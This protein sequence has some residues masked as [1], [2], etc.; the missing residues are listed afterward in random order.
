LCCGPAQDAELLPVLADS[1]GQHQDA[2]GQFDDVATLFMSAMEQHYTP[3]QI[4]DMWNWSV[5]TVIRRF[6]NEP[7]VLKI[8]RPGTRTKRRYSQISIPESTLLR[9]HERFVVKK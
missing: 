2:T 5:K 4:A 7:G 1:R 8:E 3:R 6:R 9:V